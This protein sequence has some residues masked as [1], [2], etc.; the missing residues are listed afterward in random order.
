MEFKQ[1]IINNNKNLYKLSNKVIV[2]TT[3]LKLLFPIEERYNNI[4]M[5]M[6]FNML[7]ENNKQLLTK[8]QKIEEYY[9]NKFK[10]MYYRN[11]DLVLKSQILKYKTFDPYILIKILRK[12]D[13]YK[14]IL[15]KIHNNLDNSI[16]TL[17]DI[18]PKTFFS[19][20]IY[21]DNIWVNK[22]EVTIKWKVSDIY[23]N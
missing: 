23:L 2:N 11:Q 9:F 15:T 22:G 8:I 7:D 4:V 19:M 1:N 18:Q 20:S 5:K 13:K 10:D 6:Q 17:Y 16:K 21:I 3:K 14:S 12:T